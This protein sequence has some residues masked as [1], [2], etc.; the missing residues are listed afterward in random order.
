MMLEHGSDG[1]AQVGPAYRVLT[2]SKSNAF[3]YDNNR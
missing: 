2:E 3:I 1:L